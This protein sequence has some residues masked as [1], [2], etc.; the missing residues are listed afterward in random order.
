MISITDEGSGY[1]QPCSLGVPGQPIIYRPNFN[2]VYAGS[3]GLTEYSFG[4]GKVRA[5]YD[6][7]SLMYAMGQWRID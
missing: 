1:Y 2:S 3:C 6:H 7:Y 4:Y 5:D